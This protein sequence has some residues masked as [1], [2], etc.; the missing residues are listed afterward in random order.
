LPFL[1]GLLALDLN[2]LAIFPKSKKPIVELRS[3]L[4]G[5]DF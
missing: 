1:S 3:F 4:F 5:F 2:F